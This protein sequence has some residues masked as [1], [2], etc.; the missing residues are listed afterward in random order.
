MKYTQLHCHSENSILDGVSSV[1]EIVDRSIELGHTAVAIT[2]HGNINATMTLTNECNARGIKPIMGCEFYFAKDSILKEKGLGRFHLIIIAKNKT[3]WR[4]LLELNAHSHEKGFYSKPRI[5]FKVLEKY[6]EGL[7]CLSGC[8]SGIIAVNILKDKKERAE[9]WASKFKKLFGDDFYL[10]MQVSDYNLQPKVNKGLLEISRNLNIETIVTTDAHY[11]KKE[12]SILQDMMILIMQKK[13]WKDRTKIIAAIERG[14]KVKL[15]WEISSK[16]L[17]MKSYSELKDSWRQWHSDYMTK[18]EFVRSV[19]QTTVIENKIKFWELDRTPKY[20]TMDTGDKTME[21]VIREFVKRGFKWRGL[22]GKVYEKRVQYE[23]DVI[24]NLGLDAYFV[25]LADAIMEARKRGEPIGVGRGSAA[26]SLV[27]YTLG[28]TGMDPIQHDL[29]FE[30]FINPGRKEM[31]DIDVDFSSAKR[32]KVFEYLVEKYGE[33]KVAEVTAFQNM[34]LKSALKDVSRVMGGDF[35]ITNKFTGSM[36]DGKIKD[37]NTIEDLE[38][39]YPKE[40]EAFIEGHEAHQKVLEVAMRLKGRIRNM[41]KHPAGVVITPKPLR[42]FVALQRKGDKVNVGWTEGT[43][44]KEL[45]PNGFV[46]YDIL[47]LKTLDIL[48][49]TVKAIKK[50]H[51]I[52]IDLDKIPLDDKKVYKKMS[53]GRSLGSFQFETPNMQ[54]ML[55][56]MRADS[57]EDLAALNALD[58]PGP[59]DMGMDV[60]YNKMKHGEEDE[61]TEELIK[62]V[63]KKLLPK[64]YGVIVFQ[65]Q[66]LETAKELANFSLEEADKLRKALMK[67]EKDKTKE[68]ARKKMVKKLK[69]RFIE[70]A[71]KKLKRKDAEFIWEAMFKF[72]RYGFNRSHSVSYAFIG[73]QCMWL[74]VNYPMEFFCSILNFSDKIK[75]LLYIKDALRYKIKVLPVDINK[76]RLK[77][78][79]EGKNIRYPVSHLK[80]IGKSAKIIVKNRPYDSFEDFLEKIKGMRVMKTAIMSLIRAGAFDKFGK[81]YKI[82]YQFLKLKAKKKDRDKV[83]KEKWSTM[84]ILENEKLAY[85][86]EFSDSVLEE[87]FVKLHDDYE[88]SPIPRALELGSGSV[89]RIGGIVRRIREHKTKQGV[90]AF[91]NIQFFKKSTDIT[92]F[93]DTWEKLKVRIGVGS[94][95]Y[96]NLKVNEYKK[97]LSFMLSTRDGCYLRKLELE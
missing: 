34:K 17:W 53:K 8:A 58:R 5:D 44:R 67:K 3:G 52:K 82:M 14:E 35:G 50:R 92:L 97:R 95:V 65:E 89:T 93:A 41:S 47:S 83:K 22:S 66:V 51:D 46:K 73:Y 19:K 36:N 32:H 79:P 86:F 74:K 15:P 72:A 42:S 11:A 61:E 77:F 64:T 21:Q 40:L 13:T 28:I 54:R 85:E 71:S 9:R 26:G 39:V 29:M 6:H 27:C 43:Y 48:H 37:V 78:R 90:M 23:L 4:N 7:I 94:L 45:T 49:G 81:R 76:S 24:I 70:V 16:Q 2:D 30:R 10:E 59:L 91:M 12:D 33:D 96:G 1:K 84:Q 68:K 31:P 38:E 56:A 69:I 57:F 25:I 87:L 88:C 80:Y 63:M 55:R 75:T 62:P 20:P 60:I 18:Q